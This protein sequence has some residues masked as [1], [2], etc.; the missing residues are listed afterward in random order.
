MKIK[1]NEEQSKRF[2]EMCIPELIRIEKERRANS[3][4]RCEENS[5]AVG[6]GSRPNA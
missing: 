2:V 3:E 5:R 6:E 1:L 4:Q